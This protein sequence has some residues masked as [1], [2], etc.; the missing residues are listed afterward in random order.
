MAL[1]I[2]FGAVYTSL[3]GSSVGQEIEFNLVDES[4]NKVDGSNILVVDLYNAN[5][6]NRTQ[7]LITL[8]SSN[9][10]FISFSNALGKYDYSYNGIN[11]SQDVSL[12]HDKQI[13]TVETDENGDP[14]IENGIPKINNPNFYENVKTIYI[15]YIVDNIEEVRGWSYDF[16][17]LDKIYVDN[18]INK[19]NKT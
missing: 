1:E 16:P 12:L 9:L 3:F 5:I 8:N 2:Q 18:I 6:N 10:S 19:N 4:G 13:L 15:P 11:Y 14:I 17:N 7:V